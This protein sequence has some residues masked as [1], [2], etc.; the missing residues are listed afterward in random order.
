MKVA[1][2]SADL[3]IKAAAVL[4]GVGAVYWVA[5]KAT[6][7]AASAVGAVADSAAAAVQAINPMNNENVIYQAAN[8]LTGGD[9]RST[10]GTRIYDWFN[11]DPLAPKGGTSGYNGRW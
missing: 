2:V 5:K 3:L 10:L 6:G 7:A 1:P 8:V 11:P 4:V 9:S